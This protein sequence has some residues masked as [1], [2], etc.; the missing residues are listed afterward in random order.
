MAEIVKLVPKP[1]PCE[2]EIQTTI[3]DP[4]TLGLGTVVECSCGQQ[5]KLE[6]NQREGRYWSRFRAS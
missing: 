5:F 3:G 1:H 6:E 4:E 2:A